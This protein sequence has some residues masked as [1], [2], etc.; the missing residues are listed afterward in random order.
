MKWTYSEYLEE[1]RGPID[2]P[3]ANN[4]DDP[5]YYRK[6]AHN[7]APPE[8]YHF[9]PD[10]KDDVATN[11]A[12]KNIRFVYFGWNNLTEFELNGVNAFKKAMAEK[13]IV[14]MPPN[15]HERDWLKW[16]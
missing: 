11:N 7:V 3:D 15:W 14:Q 5:R 9:I 10:R 4:P 6:Y 1:L 8:A 2:Y 16:I 12:T 13:G